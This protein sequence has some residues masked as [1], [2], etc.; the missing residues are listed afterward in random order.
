MKQ[1]TVMTGFILL[2]LMALELEAHPHGRHHGSKKRI[3]AFLQRSGICENYNASSV[4]DRSSCSDEFVNGL[5]PRNWG[6]RSLSGIV[7][8]ICLE[9][10]LEASSACVILDIA[11]DTITTETSTLE[12]CP[13]SRGNRQRRDDSSSSEE[14][15]SQ[16]DE[17]TPITT[18]TTAPATA[19]T[20]RTPVPN[21]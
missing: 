3:E 9:G 13:R 15:S 19:T 16:E 18:T 2:C 4:D 20:P 10:G 7:D 8:F 11:C 12:K 6:R 14:S 21:P 5:S 17:D 1:H